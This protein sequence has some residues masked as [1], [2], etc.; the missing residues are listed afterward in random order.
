MT[1]GAGIFCCICGAR[2][3]PELSL[4]KVVLEDFRLMNLR[5]TGFPARPGEGAWHCS[6]HYRVTGG[7]PPYSIIGA[8]SKT[9]G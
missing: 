9:G 3:Y 4:P 2:P 6:R 7:T 1:S 8:E 5:E